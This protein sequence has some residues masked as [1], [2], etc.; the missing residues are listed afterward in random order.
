MRNAQRRKLGRWVAGLALGV[1]ALGAGLAPAMAQTW[2]TRP[3]TIV[4][5]YPAGGDTDAVA[6]LLGEKLTARLGQPV[7][8]D[9]KA[10]AS[11]I[12]GTSLVNKAA[13]DGYTLLMAPSTV[14]MA[15][16][17]LKPSPATAYDM[18]ALTPIFQVGAQPLFLAAGPSAK[19]ATLGE[20]VQAS[21]TAALNYAS[22]GTGSPM[23]V[24]G[25]M[26]NRAA[27]AQFVHVPYKGIAPGLNDVVG[28]HLPLTWITYGPVEPYLKDGRIKLLAV[29][30][31]QRSP[32]A[33]N[34]PTLAELG[35]KGVEVVAWN[36]LFGPKGL[37]ADVVSRL[38]TELNAIVKDPELAQ[39][40]RVL[41]MLPV[42]GSPEVL[43]KVALSDLDRFTRIV[44]E[45]GIK[46]E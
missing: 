10:G 41:G 22:P 43:G 3:I 16:L 23:H 31:D 4:V 5:A 1:G 12:I 13:P 14:T 45:L 39:R 29:A 34:V 25:E 37:P 26:F 21:K 28:G 9:N 33:P 17:V 6:R 42:G 30:Q 2:P 20:A 44:G 35:V 38:N 7:I 32:L 8:V 18:R 40:L 19:F 36:G 15:Q 27:G 24:L 11:G 46:A